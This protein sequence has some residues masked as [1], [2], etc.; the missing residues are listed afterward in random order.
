VKKLLL[1]AVLVQSALMSA[2]SEPVS[3]KPE[4]VIKAN[5]VFLPAGMLNAAL[6]HQLS[7]KYTLQGDVFISPWKSFFGHFLQVYSAG[8]EGRYYFTEAFDKWYVGANVSGIR[9]I[10]E[11]WNY[12]GDGTYQYKEGQPVYNV[13]DLYQDGFGFMLGATV[14]YQ[15]PLSERWKL[16]FFLTGGSVQTFY[17]GKHKTLPVRYNDEPD[18]TWNRSGEWL[19]YRGGIMIGYTL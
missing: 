5:G 16:D 17:K 7:E 10:M 3:D 4:N 15:V 13:K 1:S 2:Q 6:E 11:K 9:F 19:P 12:W 14:G 8:V 18:R